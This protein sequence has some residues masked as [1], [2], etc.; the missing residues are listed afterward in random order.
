MAN[1]DTLRSFVAGLSM[2]GK[3]VPDPWLCTIH[4]QIRRPQKVSA[5]PRCIV[6]PTASVSELCG[7]VRHWWFTIASSCFRYISPT[8]A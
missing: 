4:P 5:R 8:A 1:Q 6:A 3:E 2:K 7:T